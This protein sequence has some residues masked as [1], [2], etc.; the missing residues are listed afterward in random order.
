MG[1]D[2]HILIMSKQVGDVGYI[3][4]NLCLPSNL[5]RLGPVGKKVSY[6]D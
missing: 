6:R 1:S 3:T 4:P 5:T 2:V